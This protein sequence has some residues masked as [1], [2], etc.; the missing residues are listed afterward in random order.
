MFKKIDINSLPENVRGLANKTKT[1]LLNIIDRKDNVEKELNIRIEN[2]NRK[3]ADIEYAY[4][5]E[6]KAYSEKCK[7][8][9][10]IYE[11]YKALINE[12]Q[13]LQQDYLDLKEGYEELEAEDKT[14]LNNSKSL[15]NDIDRLLN[16]KQ[17]LEAMNKTLNEKCNS[18][19]NEKTNLF[20]KINA[21]DNIKKQLIDDKE[22]LSKDYRIIL[23]KLENYNKNNN[24][25]KFMFAVYTII[26]IVLLLCNLM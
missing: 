11:K 13:K 14:L 8:C 9:S 5:V 6:K 26:L 19:D 21:I 1:E 24:F 25:Y 22:K 23:D 4:D 16:E 17:E 20:H 10:E 3:V 2:M 18:L 12:H 7:E 15:K